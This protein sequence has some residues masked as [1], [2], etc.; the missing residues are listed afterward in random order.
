MLEDNQ[1]HFPRGETEERKIETLSTPGY[2]RDYLL[3]I[4][5]YIY[6]LCM[7]KSKYFGFEGFGYELKL[8]AFSDNVHIIRVVDSVKEF[9]RLITEIK[10]FS[11]RHIMRRLR[12]FW[13]RD[14]EKKIVNL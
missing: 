10:Q 4:I 13:C 11:Y 6:S 3:C 1:S 9:L 14:R 2:V 8:S 7:K 12:F 5:Y